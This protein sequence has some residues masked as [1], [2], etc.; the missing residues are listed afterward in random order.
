VTE[1]AIKHLSNQGV[2]ALVMRWFA[3]G[4]F[5]VALYAAFPEHLWL[6]TFGVVSIE[7]AFD[8][9]LAV[10]Q[11]LL[12]AA[13]EQN[14]RRHRIVL[15]GLHRISTGEHL[16]WQDVATVANAQHEQDA[17]LTDADSGKPRLWLSILYRFLS[18]LAGLGVALAI[19]SVIRGG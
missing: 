16:D 13:N 17:T 11:A 9:A 18:T 10:N 2:S 3:G 7:G 15:E 19:A 6:C 14:I 5:L 8:Q 12:E 1:R 4:C